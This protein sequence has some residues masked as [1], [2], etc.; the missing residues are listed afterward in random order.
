[1]VDT[2]Q[3]SNF[4]SDLEMALTGQNAEHGVLFHL[5]VEVTVR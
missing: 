4:R 3:E 5:A 1:M 2:S